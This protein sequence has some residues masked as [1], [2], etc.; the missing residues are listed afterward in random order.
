MKTVNYRAL[1]RFFAAI[2]VLTALSGCGTVKQESAMEWMQR[3]P[4]VTDP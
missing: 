4:M 1:Y 2:V 3:Q